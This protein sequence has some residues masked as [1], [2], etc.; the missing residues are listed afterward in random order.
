MCA[1]MCVC[2]RM[3]ERL[4]IYVS[5]SVCYD[6]EKD[7]LFKGAI[8]VRGE[9]IRA[10]D[11]VFFS[12]SFVLFWRSEW[13]TFKSFVS[14]L[15]FSSYFL[16]YLFCCRKSR[17]FSEDFTIFLRLL[18]FS[19]SRLY[20][21]SFFITGKGVYTV[22]VLNDWNEKSFEVGYRVFF[23]LSSRCNERKI[24]LLPYSL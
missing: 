19:T 8:F 5:A 6:S 18:S 23:A 12:P 21:Y 7:Y 17:V 10:S 4:C 24:T 11:R 20:I 14:S 2:K 16:R 3:R 13:K 15:F 1:C 9:K 22:V